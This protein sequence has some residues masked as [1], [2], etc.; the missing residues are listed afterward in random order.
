MTIT[1][2][3]NKRAKT[4]EAAKAFLES[5]RDKDGL[6][7]AEDGAAYDKMEAEIA[8]YSTDIERMCLSLIHI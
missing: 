7:S 3:L 1:E 4:W 5:H 8:A 6:L 2:L